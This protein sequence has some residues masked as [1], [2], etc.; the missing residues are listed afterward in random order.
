MA[1][2]GSLQ[3]LELLYPPSRRSTLPSPDN[4]LSLT[5]LDECIL[6]PQLLTR[7]LQL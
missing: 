3:L 4:I 5:H 1:C 2:T 7:Q 6:R